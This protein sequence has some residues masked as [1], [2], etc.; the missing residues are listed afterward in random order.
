MTK[1]GL[2]NYNNL[3]TALQFSVPIRDAGIT[4]VKPSFKGI[5][6]GGVK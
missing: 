2:K 6:F 4:G 1:G 5:R 3:F